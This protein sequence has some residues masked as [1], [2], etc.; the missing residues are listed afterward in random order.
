MV[1]AVTGGGVSVVADLLS[2]PGGSDSILEANV[3]YSAAALR[4][5]LRGRINQSCSS[6]TA[7]AMAMASYQRARWLS[8]L[9]DV[10]IAPNDPHC[11]G[12]GCTAALVSDRLKRGDHRMYVSLQTY[13]R[14]QITSLVINKGQRARDAEERLVA[15]VV[16]NQ[17]AA[18]RRL[19]ELIQL[20]LDGHEQ[21]QSEATDAPRAWSEILVGQRN[22]VRVGLTLPPRPDSVRLVFPGSFDPLHEGHRQMVECAAKRLQRPV[23][24][25]LSVAN[26]E[27]PSLDFIEI[28]S[29]LRRFSATDTIWLTRAA[30]FLEKIQ[31]FPNTVFLV[32]TDT[33]VRIADARFYGADEAACQ[34][35]LAIMAESGCR[36]LVFGRSTD[37]KFRTLSE[38]NLPEPLRAICDE[39][40]EGDYRNDISSTS[41][42]ENSES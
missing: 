5:H 29:R 31:I 9:D 8:Q 34:R 42:R 38:L 18:S 19:D 13:G 11:V 25:E 22:A 3:P 36:F 12:V 39:V 32:G 4:A 41:I 2:V 37:G 24:F 14:T 21:I 26:A 23:E 17:I 15:D 35:A 28:E 27:K 10:D 20:N 6:R 1:I 30:S 33:V 40:P 16:L 7:R